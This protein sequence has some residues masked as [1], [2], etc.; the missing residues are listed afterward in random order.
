MKILPE[1]STI[2][3]SALLEVDLNEVNNEIVDLTNGIPNGGRFSN[4]AKADKEI[5]IKNYIPP[6]AIARLP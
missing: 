4:Y 1:G 6:K 5:L 2:R 3:D